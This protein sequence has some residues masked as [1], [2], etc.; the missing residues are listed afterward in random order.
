MRNLNKVYGFKTPVR[1][2]SSGQKQALILLQPELGKK[3][4]LKKRDDGRWR[5]GPDKRR[6]LKLP[7]EPK[8]K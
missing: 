3:G 8:K 6:Q 7:L 2:K 1:K 4:A 5:R